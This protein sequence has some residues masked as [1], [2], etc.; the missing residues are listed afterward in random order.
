MSFDVF[1]VG[2]NGVPVL[3]EGAENLDAAIGRVIGLRESFPGDYVIVSQATG[4]RILFTSKGWNKT[5]LTL[6]A[7]LLSGCRCDC[8]FEAELLF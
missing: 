4:R 2:Q 3:L 6:T 7:T 8:P 5:K 1:K